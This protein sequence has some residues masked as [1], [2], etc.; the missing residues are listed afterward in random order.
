MCKKHDF[1]CIFSL[2]LSECNKSKL[3]MFIKYLHNKK[4]FLGFFEKLYEEVFIP[5]HAAFILLEI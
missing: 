5:T 3:S 1:F 2:H 4:H